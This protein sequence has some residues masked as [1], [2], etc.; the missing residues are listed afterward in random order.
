MPVYKCKKGMWEKPCDA[1]SEDAAGTIFKCRDCS[2][3]PKQCEGY[4][5]DIR[6]KLPAEEKVRL[7]LLDLSRTSP[8]RGTNTQVVLKLYGNEIKAAYDRGHSCKK[9]SEVLGLNDVF[10]SSASLHRYFRS[11]KAKQL[12]G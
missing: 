6:K 10:I 8:K 1:L 12:E 4:G 5:N 9:I 7:V 11:V 3:F 2:L